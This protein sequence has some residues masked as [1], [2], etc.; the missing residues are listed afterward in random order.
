MLDE[1]CVKS[2][3]V[4]KLNWFTLEKF[5]SWNPG[6][7]LKSKEVTLPSDKMVKHMRGG[8]FKLGRAT[9]LILPTNS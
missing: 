6:L 5:G 2:L 1:Q 4:L 7:S 9:T 3:S 8:A